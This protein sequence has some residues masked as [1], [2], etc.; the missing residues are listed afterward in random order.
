MQVPSSHPL[1]NID[2]LRE[3]AGTA[4]GSLL[5]LTASPSISR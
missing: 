3:E 5:A 1:L 2:E 4:M